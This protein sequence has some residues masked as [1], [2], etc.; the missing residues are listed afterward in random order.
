MED[1]TT[2]SIIGL[3]ST[4]SICNIQ[5][6]QLTPSNVIYAECCYDKCH[7]FIGMQSVIWLSVIIP[8]SA[9]ECEKIN[10]IQQDPGF[11]PHHGQTV[12]NVT[13]QFE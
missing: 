12:I 13:I 6:K 8:G 2:L 1:A 10:E 11:D 7:V 4:L 5:H 3:I 9:V